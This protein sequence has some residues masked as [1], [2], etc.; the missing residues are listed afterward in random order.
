MRHL[1]SLLLPHRLRRSSVAFIELLS[2]GFATIGARATL[3]AVAGQV[4]GIQPTSV[5]PPSRAMPAT[6][7]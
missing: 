4:L 6:A 1:P 2:L 5:A 7:G 3:I